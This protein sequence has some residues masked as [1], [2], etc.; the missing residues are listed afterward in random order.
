M[1]E[2]IERLIMLNDLLINDVRDS[3]LDAI[4]VVGDTYYKKS[5]KA[6]CSCNGEEIEPLEIL[7]AGNEPLFWECQTCD[8]LHLLKSRI[9]TEALLSPAFGVW[10]DPNAWGWKEKSDFN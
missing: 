9:E 5:P 2:P 8:Y 3:I 10:T 1:S 4:G 7:G 6:C